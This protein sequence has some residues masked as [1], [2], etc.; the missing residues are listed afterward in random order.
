MRC[1]CV[2]LAALLMVA[3]PCGRTVSAE[4]SAAA[5][6][7]KIVET[8]Q[9]LLQSVQQEA[10]Q[11]QNEY[12]YF[13]D[14]C[15][16]VYAGQKTSQERYAN[17]R[18]ELQS[19]LTVQQAMNKQL[20]D[21][22]TQLEQETAETK[23]TIQQA[24]SMRQNEHNDYLIEQKNLA[25]ML[26]VLNRAV[27]VLATSSNKA[28]LVS[29]AQSIQQIAAKSP[30]VSDQQRDSLA[31]F[32]QMVS[33]NDGSSDDTIGQV[34]SVTQV[35][36]ELIENFQTSMSKASEQERQGLE[37]YDSLI[38]L[39]KQSY[40]QLVTSKDSKDALLAESL[41]RTA[42]VQR[43]L[44]DSRILVQTGGQYVQAVQQVCGDKSNQ[45]ASRSQVR[46]DMTERLQQ[47]VANLGGDVM[48]VNTFQQPQQ[49]PQMQQQQTSFI[50]PMG[51]AAGLPPLAMIQTGMQV[52]TGMLSMA[53]P[54]SNGGGGSFSSMLQPPMQASQPQ[55]MSFSQ[56]PQL[57]MPLQQRQMPPQQMS[58]SQMAQGLGQQ[59]QM[60]QGQMQQQTPSLMSIGQ[61]LDNAPKQ[62]T[63]TAVKNMVSQMEGQMQSEQMDENK[64]KNWCDGEISKNQA[65][66]DDK[67]VKLQRLSTKIDNQK[68]MVGELDQDLQ[69]L[70]K[71]SGSL[72]EQLR[73]FG[74]L[75]LNERSGY[76]KSQQNHQMAMQ[77][78]KQATMILQR[79][80]SL[81]QESSQGL[82]GSFL[83]QGNL[84]NQQI[85]AVS[86]A[87]ID[88]LSQLLTRY[89]ELQTASDKS[90]NQAQFDME[91]FSQLNQNLANVLQQTRTY[92]SSL[93]LQSMSE[94]DSD[95][96]DQNQLKTQ[97][98][99]VTAYV[100]RLRQACADILTHYDEQKQRR[101]SNLQA[102][103]EAK[104]VINV[105]NAEE[106]RNQLSS[107][108]QKTDSAAAGMLAASASLSS[109]PSQQQQRTPEVSLASS[110]SSL[111]DLTSHMSP[112]Q[113]QQPMLG[114]PQQQQPML[115]APQ[116]PMLT[117]PP[118][119]QQQLPKPLG[120]AASGVA[121]TSAILGDLKSL[122]DIN[123]ES[124]QQR[125]GELNMLPSASQPNSLPTGNF[126][127]PSVAGMMQPPQ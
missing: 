17:L 30:L 87:A 41:Q 35:L 26:S 59:Q 66:V 67:S 109:V 86:A 76:T 107:M 89:E 91:R 8:L 40:L 49:Q 50:Q 103:E 97:V 78:L 13:Y 127:A 37:Q 123:F 44:Q 96:E 126:N 20:K 46:S 77:I 51:G 125:N 88:S 122:Q 75:R 112:V 31:S 70:T 25:N 111:S 57:Q 11:D 108:A 94:L 124:S 2:S 99:S 45:W 68:E 120:L 92:K 118:Q 116:Q 80:N 119:P 3:V 33:S 63:Y 60:P 19:K 15:N 38:R 34:S 115:S 69:L 32:A 71:E 22:T 64:H 47:T 14:W 65:V 83:Q 28:T 23:Q 27:D 100:Q 24:A 42:Q 73:A 56:M 81:A 5:P 104:G 43:S 114:I 53:P 84:Q 90:D 82:G 113:Q 39:K 10:Q 16:Q 58:F 7:M 85:S 79:F 62:N 18:A 12:K 21:E 36:K 61:H 102:L 72:Q 6:I 29:V 105:D 98:E 101:E 106:V 93:R 48:G 52:N 95:K 117:A 74:Q 9:N 1:S 110:L 55:Q 121:S 4:S 54:P